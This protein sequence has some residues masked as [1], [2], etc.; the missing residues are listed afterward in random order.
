[1]L[2]LTLG[3]IFTLFAVKAWTEGDTATI[4]GS[5]AFISFVF[6]VLAYIRFDKKKENIT[7]EELFRQAG[8]KLDQQ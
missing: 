7:K 3:S 6:L 1:M 5:L 2:F 4:W 8:V